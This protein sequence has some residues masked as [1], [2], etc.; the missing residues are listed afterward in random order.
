MKMRTARAAAFGG[1]NTPRKSARDLAIRIRVKMQAVSIN[2][3]KSGDW[4]APQVI[5]SLTLWTKKREYAGVRI[6]WDASGCIVN[7]GPPYTLGLS[8]IGDAVSTV[9]GMRGPES[10][11]PE[12]RAHLDNAWLNWGI[13]VDTEASNKEG[14]SS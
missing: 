12:Q 7:P 4:P 8:R 5:G 9:R 6:D 1:R 11:T 2:L 14:P 10:L 13:E 3:E